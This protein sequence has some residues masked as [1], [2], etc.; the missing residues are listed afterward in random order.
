MFAIVWKRSSQTHTHNQHFSTNWPV[1]LTYSLVLVV[2]V[3]E[4]F[5]F[6]SFHLLYCFIYVFTFDLTIAMFFYF[7]FCRVSGDPK[8]RACAAFMLPSN[9]KRIIFSNNLFFFC[10]RRSYRF[11]SSRN[12][13][14]I[15]FSSLIVLVYELMFTNCFRLTLTVN[16]LHNSLNRHSKKDGIR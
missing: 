14:R 10:I 7:C 12:R 8:R 3:L 6:I 15:Y 11:N 9:V 16:N 13:S 5:I 4:Y 1:R 2:F